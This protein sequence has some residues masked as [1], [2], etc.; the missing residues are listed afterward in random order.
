[1]LLHLRASQGELSNLRLVDC[2]RKEDKGKVIHGTMDGPPKIE[3]VKVCFKPR[4]SL[5]S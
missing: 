1:M 5:R 4:S 3:M 2:M